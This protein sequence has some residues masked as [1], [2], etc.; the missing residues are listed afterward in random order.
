MKLRFLGFLAALLAA[1]LFGLTAAAEDRIALVIGNGVYAKAPDLPNPPN[2]AR[3]MA[4][5]LRKLGFEV[6]EYLD[7]S[8]KEMRVAFKTFAQRL[9]QGGGDAIGLFFY[10]GHGIQLNGTNYLV[11]VDA[12]I[13]SE[14][15][16][17]I[18][19]VSAN[20]VLEVMAFAKNRLNFV[21]LDACRNNPF[22]RS[23]RALNRGGGLAQMDAP[24]GTL[25]AYATAP[26][27][28]AADGDG[29]NSPYTGALAEAMA[30]PGIPVEQ[31]FKRVRINVRA[32]TGKR[33]TS[34]EASSLTGDFYF[35]PAPPAAAGSGETAAPS[36]ETVFWQSIRVSESPTDFQ[37][38]L[39][40]YPQ[41]VFAPLARNR[42]AALA[43]GFSLPEWL[44][45]VAKVY[46]GE[47]TNQVRPDP[48]RVVT[49][50]EV[51]GGKL[52]GTYTIFEPGGQTSGR[53]EGSR[54]TEE[55][56]GVLR[57]WDVY[58]EGTLEVEFSAD[59]G[60]FTGRWQPD[61]LPNGGGAWSGRR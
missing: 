16:V 54:E 60:S 29:V 59:L 27:D 61:G 6:L 14:T 36:P 58:G 13:E 20:S 10:A 8:Q 11:P 40:K 7:I 43:P 32:V 50:L 35:N 55:G 1:L 33:Q 3:L 5:T 15:D 26:G 17:K 21:I 25:I 2:D 23:F 12:S 18:D 34:W 56:K 57:W 24:S 51:Q 4:A 49:R 48:D 22:T 47:I 53:L 37:A 46:E 38:Y 52:A 41:G 39:D 42:M 44:K 30:T 28:V 45:A 9:E 31:M 19:S